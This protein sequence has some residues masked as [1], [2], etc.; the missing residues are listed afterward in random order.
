MGHIPKKSLLAILRTV[1]ELG[2][3]PDKMAVHHAAN[4]YKA[5]GGTIQ[6]LDQLHSLELL[7]RQ[8]TGQE[9]VYFVSP[10]GKQLLEQPL[11]GQIQTLSKNSLR[12]NTPKAC[13]IC[14]STDRLTWWRKG[15]F[16]PTHLNDDT[17]VVQYIPRTSQLGW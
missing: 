17:P 16:C 14:A 1:K 13:V 4:I 11:E 5:V 9:F 15:Y 12:E 6:R 7:N 3:K 8:S 2:G 10:R